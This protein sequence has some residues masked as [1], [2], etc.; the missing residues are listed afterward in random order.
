MQDIFDEIIQCI[1]NEKDAYGTVYVKKDNLLSFYQDHQG[2]QPA[3]ARIPAR[4]QYRE[5]P[6]ERPAARRMEMPPPPPP[7]SQFIAPPDVS[8]LG[9]D[10]LRKAAYAC[11][12]CRLCLERHSVVF[13][14]GDEHAQLMFIGE[15][16]G[17]DEDAQGVPFVGR[18]GQLLTRMIAAM[19]FRRE[20]VYIANIVKC[21]PPGNRN[22]EEDEMATC[23]PYL[24]RQIELVKPKVIVLLGNTAL[25]G[26]L[27]RSGI[28]RM[29]GH[30]LDFHGI[31]VMPTFH[32]SYLLRYEAGKKDAWSD[33]QQV[34][35]VFGKV[36]Q[37]QSR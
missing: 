29:R 15:G 28:S 32:P 35:K 10:D 24:L 6:A 22:P 14:D 2:A 26:L 12:G 11:R 7:P 18:A 33:L 27:K 5:V 19:G 37:K 21:R 23:I 3:P 17:A 16:P 20:E 4:S 8:N 30:W 9:W 36:Y 34:M 31:M 13:S 1:R 25:K